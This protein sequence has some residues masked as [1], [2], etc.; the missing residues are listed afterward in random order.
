[1][2]DED[3]SNSDWAVASRASGWNDS[4]AYDG[5]QAEILI[6]NRALTNIELDDIISYAQL[7]YGTPA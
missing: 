1:M 7:K 5:L 6:Y 3:F 2:N 4:D